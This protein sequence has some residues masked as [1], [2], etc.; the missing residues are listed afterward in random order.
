MPQFQIEWTVSA[1]SRLQEVVTRYN[2]DSGARLTVREWI[3]LHLEEIAV[4][5]GLSQRVLELHR[6]A[7]TE[8]NAAIRAEKERLLALVRKEG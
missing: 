4:Q 6:Q 5:E 8:L 2:A 1:L 7:E 3:T